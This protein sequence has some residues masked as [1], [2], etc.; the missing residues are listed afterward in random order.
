MTKYQWHNAKIVAKTSD[1]FD[2]L[3]DN[4]CVRAI[5]DLVEKGLL[6]D[7]GRKRWSKETGRYEI[8]WVITE[9]GQQ[10]ATEL[11]L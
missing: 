3:P 2:D 4:E 6:A 7:S 9:L 8:V 1:P 5:R 11:G 10:T